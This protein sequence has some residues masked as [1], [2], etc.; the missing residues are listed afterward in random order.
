MTPGRHRFGSSSLV[1]AGAAYAAYPVRPFRPV[2]PFCLAVAPLACRVF[3]Q[4]NSNSNAVLRK[5]R[6]RPATGQDP[7]ISFRI[8]PRLK[9]AIDEWRRTQLNKPSRSEAIRGFI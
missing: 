7:V 2:R 9:R 4:A 3:V 5:K 8:G 6:G 1:F